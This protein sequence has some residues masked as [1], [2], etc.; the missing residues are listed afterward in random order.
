RAAVL[1]SYENK[2][3]LTGLALPE[4]LNASHIVPWAKNEQR[5]AD[6]RNG[7]CLNALHDRTFDRGLITFDEDMRM[8]VSPRIAEIHENKVQKEML[9]DFRGCALTLPKRFQPDAELMAYHRR[10]VFC[11]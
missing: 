6:P 3:A 10:E 9:M 2:C 11:E 8:L 4:L 7:L 1:A 5:R